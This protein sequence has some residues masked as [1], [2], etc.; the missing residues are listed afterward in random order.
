MS[1]PSSQPIA[2]ID[3]GTNSVHLLVAKSNEDGRISILDT[4]KA[5]L[6]LGED[7]DEAGNLVPEA[8]TKTIQALK[9]MQ[10]IA[11]SYQPI[12]RVVATHATRSARNY[13]DFFQKI[14]D[15]SSIHIS[16]IDGE[17]E[18]RLVSLGMQEGLALDDKTFLGV[19]IGGGSTEIIVCQDQK[20]R[21]VRSLEL[22]AVTL[23]KRFLK[24]H[25]IKKEHIR[26]LEHEVEL[27]LGP[28]RTH[29]KGLKFDCAVICSGAAKTL[30]QMHSQ[31]FQEKKLEDANG[32]H[33]TA[34]D[35]KKLTK[36]IHRLR[37]PKH[38]SEHW[39]LHEDRAHIILAGSS[40]LNLIG[41]LFDVDEWIISTYGVRE[42]L[43]I[44]TIA[45]LHGPQIKG[46]DDVRWKN[47]LSLSKKFAINDDYARQV[48]NLAL[49]IFDQLGEKM[50]SYV[51]QD[52]SGVQIS[53]RGILRAAAWLH[54]CGKFISYPRYHKHS[55]YLIA[56]S[57]LMGFSQKER[58]MIG[59]VARFH[60]KGK[61]NLKNYD[62]RELSGKDCKRINFL[63]SILRIAAAA[64][65]TRQGC[66]TNIELH[67]SEEG[68]EF[69]FITDSKH[70]PEVDLYK[71]SKEKKFFEEVIEHPLVLKTEYKDNG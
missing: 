22:G 28:L 34:G 27:K 2:A 30:A 48:T 25:S 24:G 62:C 14:Y 44:D 51:K 31:D 61:A 16:L 9:R 36:S 68:L 63:A 18:A 60:R 6:R 12:Y 13:K 64:N 32:Y 65:R 66:I 4:D 29:I 59:L 45:R 10:A 7:L 33:L 54:E 21:F 8:F 37:S 47:I 35:I 20:V 38:I 56:N 23:N 11:A 46:F 50:P 40:I 55:L 19:D 3:I 67:Q 53:D 26:N 5:V 57:R 52:A 41:K 71:I 42:G 69:I 1:S 39:H 49:E 17:E 15:E 58:Q 43:V 70:A